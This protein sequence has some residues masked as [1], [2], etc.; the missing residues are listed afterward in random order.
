MLLQR[1]TENMDSC[2]Q[3]VYKRIVPVNKLL[4]IYEAS[5]LSCIHIDD[6]TRSRGMRRRSLPCLRNT[7]PEVW[8]GLM[9]TPSAV[10]MALVAAGTLNSSAANCK[11]A[12]NGASSGTLT[13]RKGSLLSE[14]KVILN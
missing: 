5:N 14:A 3:S 10:I 4:A 13:T 1:N 2:E 7:R 12:V 6:P 8:A 11:T 9:P